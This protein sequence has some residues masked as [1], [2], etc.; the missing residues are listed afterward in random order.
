MPKK[1]GKKRPGSPKGRKEKAPPGEMTPW[2]DHTRWVRPPTPPPKV[3]ELPTEVK[4]AAQRGDAVRVQRWLEDDNGH[5]DAQWWPVT[6]WAV[7]AA[8]N[9]GCTMLMAAAANRA[10]HLVVFLLDHG[11]AIDVQDAKGDTALMLAAR[12]RLR[13]YGLHDATDRIVLTLL[14]KGASVTLQNHDGQTARSIINPVFLGGHN[15]Y[16]GP[17]HVDIPRRLLLAPPTLSASAAYLRS[18]SHRAAPTLPQRSRYLDRG[19]A[20]RAE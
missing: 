2:I 12:L 16:P 17:A 9:Q 4:V 6:S 5:V 10:E 13:G 19:A 7:P 14:R 18:P 20:R 8:A 1:G 11:A 3:T 15:S